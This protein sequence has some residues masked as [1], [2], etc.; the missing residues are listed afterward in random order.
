ML[1]RFEMHIPFALMAYKGR[2]LLPLFVLLIKKHALFYSG[3][4]MSL[5]AI[6]PISP[7]FTLPFPTF[8]CP[9]GVIPCFFYLLKTCTVCSCVMYGGEK[10]ASYVF[11]CIH[12]SNLPRCTAWHR[13]G[14]EEGRALLEEG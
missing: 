1:F 9:V 8:I 7:L 4:V 13:D 10:S 2:V 11:D 6:F 5:F 14:T 3:S 12:G